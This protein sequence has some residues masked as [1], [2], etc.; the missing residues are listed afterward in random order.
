MKEIVVCSGGMIDVE[1][2]P[3]EIKILPL[4]HVYSQKGDF[5]VDDESVELIRKQF[6]N[7]SLDIVI[8]YEHQTL[9][10]M[11]APAGG[12][13]K[14]I[15]KGEDAVVAKVE[16]TDKAKE[17]LKNKE[18]RYLSPV[19]MVRKKDRKAAS[20]HSVALTNTPA[21]DGMFALVNSDGIADFEKNKEENQMDMKELAAILGLPET[22]MEEDVKKALG[23]AKAALE[24]NKA[25]EGKQEGENSEDGE[26]VPVANSVVLSLLG[27]K[28]DAKT[29][30]V[31]AAVMA[32]KAG[33]GNDEILALK[34]ELKERNAEDMVQMALKEGKITAAQKEWAKTYALSDKEGFK[35]FVEKAPVVVPQGKM[36]LKDAPAEGKQDY[37]MEILKNCDISKEDVEK[38][39]KED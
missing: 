19:V 39:Y 31:A 22:A 33:S 3:E 21:I 13:I 6:K 32:L 38:Y 25:G 28:D 17:Y 30:D 10:D 35:S 34:E 14:D 23:A 29:E 20:I 27:L 11:Q 36:E 37:D 12:W 24:A 8:D 26:A 18:Y 16:W 2:V 9:K 5:E 1:G 7:R 4:G 15:Y